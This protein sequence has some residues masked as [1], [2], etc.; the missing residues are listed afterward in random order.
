M[1]KN[2]SVGSFGKATPAKVAAAKREGGVE[3]KKAVFADNMRK[4]AR[5]HKRSSN[6]GGSR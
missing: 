6:R 3:E 1:E 2:G 4:I 5:K